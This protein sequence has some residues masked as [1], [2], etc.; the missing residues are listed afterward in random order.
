MPGQNKTK[1]K[2][3]Q[4]ERRRSSSDI[5]WGEVQNENKGNSWKRKEEICRLIFWFNKPQE[6][7]WRYFRTTYWWNDGF[8]N[9]T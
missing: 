5:K 9:A 1:Q 7:Q 3:N 8:N 4:K 6:N 2:V